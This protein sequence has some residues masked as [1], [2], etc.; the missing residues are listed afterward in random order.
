[1]KKSVIIVSVLLL[2][3]SSAHAGWTP[4]VRISDQV[5]SFRPRMAV[6]GDTLHVVYW[7]SQD[8]PFYL[9]STNN[10]YNWQVPFCLM[11][12]DTSVT[13]TSPLIRT[14]G[15][16]IVAIWYN[17]FRNS[18]RVNWGCRYSSNGGGDW[19][20]ISYVLPSD[21]PMLQH[22]TFNLSATQIFLISSRWDQEIIFE[23]TKSTNWGDTWT[24]PSEIFRA[25]QIGRLDI[26]SR[27]DT[28]HFVWVG[29]FTSQYPVWETYYIKSEDAGITWTDNIPLVSIDN[30]GSMYPSISINERGDIVVCWVDF[31]YSPYMWTGDLFVR[32]SYNGGDSWTDEEQITFTHTAASPRVIWR[33]DSIHVAW[34]DS[35]FSGG[36]DPFYM[37]SYDNGTTWGTEQRVDDDPMESFTPDLCLSGDNIHVVWDENRPYDPGR[38]IYYS[39]WEEESAVGDT[40]GNQLP[41]DFALRAYPNPFNSKTR[42]T[43]KNLKGGE[44]EIYNI[45]GQKVKAFEIAKIKEGQVEWD[46]RDALGNKVTS[47]IYFARARC[48]DN[49]ATIKLLYLK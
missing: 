45:T 18:S 41:E 47:G 35:R 2:A 29:R 4:A 23:F 6:N 46:A 27:G 31:K 3:A 10:G 17:R 37:A 39:R 28:I 43:Y 19:Q 44:I 24:I 21:D 26:T 13:G 1:M 33:G 36:P 20:E 22:C 5:T 15:D 9:R 42:L 14:E 25:L 7:T 49:Y 30:W 12:T 11:D 48:G 34:E 40:Y 32:Y 8:T 38:G 16:N